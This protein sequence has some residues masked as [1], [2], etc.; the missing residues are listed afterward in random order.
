MLLSSPDTAEGLRFVASDNA[1]WA[2]VA[3][4][5]WRRTEE[6]LRRAE[7]SSKCALKEWKRVLGTRKN[8]AD[9]VIRPGA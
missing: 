6:C 5:G 8:K 3:R 1:L 2:V 4:C 7:L 9:S